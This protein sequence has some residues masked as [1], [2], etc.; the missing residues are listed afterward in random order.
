MNFSESAPDRFR[1]GFA[2]ALAPEESAQACDKSQHFVELGLG[3]AAHFREQVG[4]AN[5]VGIEEQMRVQIRAITSQ[6]HQIGHAPSHY[7]E[8][9]QCA[10]KL[11]DRAQLQ[12]LDA[13]SILHDV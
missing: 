3:R 8:Q 2:V 13:A 11:L 12:R 10:L 6:P 4:T 9:R 1:A 5:F 7:Q